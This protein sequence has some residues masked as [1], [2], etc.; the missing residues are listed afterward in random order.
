[1][2]NKWLFSQI[3]LKNLLV[4]RYLFC[5]IMLR[6]SSDS[7]ILFKTFFYYEISYLNFPFFLLFH[8][9]TNYFMI[10]YFY[11]V[12]AWKFCLKFKL[13]RTSFQKLIICFKITILNFL[14]LIYNNNFHQSN[15]S[16]YYIYC[17]FQ[18]EIHY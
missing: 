7:W 2:R 9:F 1:M 4:F 18:N 3:T 8:L 16:E 15:Y 13:K 14:N 10:N 5:S 6:I 11:L 12:Y 17:F